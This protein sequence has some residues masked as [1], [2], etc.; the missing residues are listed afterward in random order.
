M[1][2]PYPIEKFEIDVES[3]PRPVSFRVAKSVNTNA[4]IIVDIPTTL[5]V[6]TY[7]SRFV[8]D[9]ELGDSPAA[10]D[11]ISSAR[12]AIV[13]QSETLQF[14]EVLREFI[15]VV[16]KF[17]SQEQQGRSPASV[18]HAVPVKNLRRRLD[19]LAAH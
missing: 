13:S 1:K 6:I 10:D 5:W 3:R 16:T 2:G 9:H 11:S 19:E 18:L 7:F 17:G 8:A 14:R 15:E 4:A 12:E